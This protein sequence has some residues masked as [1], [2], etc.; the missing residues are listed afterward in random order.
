MKSQEIIRRY[1]SFFKA[2][3]HTVIPSAP[4]VPENDPT[5]LFTTAGMHP[6][7]PYFLGTEH[8]SG[9]KRLTSCQKCLRTV[10]IDEVGDNR[11]NTFFEMLGNWSLGDYFK[12]DSI[13]WSWQFLTDKDQGLGLDPSRLYITVF[14]GDS[15]AP[16]D[17]Q[18]VDLWR[19][20]FS[21]VGID[22][23]VDRPVE[24]GGRVFRLAKESN[25]WG[26]A[27]QTGP[28]G[29]DTEIYYDL[30]EGSGSLSLE[31]GMPDFDSG[32]LLEI[33]NNV[34]MQYAK[35]SDGTFGLL[36]QKNVDTGMGVERIA[37]ILQGTSTA[38]ETDL[39][40]PL[41]QH[42]PPLGV[43]AGRI[44]A[45]HL[46]AAC[47]LISDGVRPA[48]KDRG[49][50]LRRLIRRALLH[51]GQPD[52]HWLSS[53]M[54]AMQEIY[55]GRYPELVSDATEIEAVL[56]GE[57]A[58]FQ[59]TLEQ[60]KREIVK[61]Q[62]LT[63][64]DAFDL[65]QSYGF[66]LELTQEYAKEQGVAVNESEFAEEFKRHQDLSRTASA[67]QFRSGLADQ[68]E[69][70]TKYHTATHLLQASLRQVLGES[71]EQKG[72]NINA[73]RLR[74]DFSYPEKLTPEQLKDVEEMVNREITAGLTISSQSMSPEAARDQG[75]LGF[76][77]NKYG[78]IVSVFSIGGFSKE[79]CTG[80]HVVQ[81]NELGTFR[82]LKEEAVSAGVR[83]IKAILE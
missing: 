83:R 66:P 32:R 59:K 75:A 4:L 67:G 19:E 60:G 81:T 30:G 63:G 14:A 39:F 18:S 40:K 33:W 41:F 80:P 29:P 53:I 65:Y 73:E 17:L 44:V 37:T 61:R 8:P 25:W 82:I 48:N 58:K 3:D 6:L 42:L 68:S 35:N 64:K 38:Y 21:A 79:I 10:D 13:R 72:S 7:V 70:S 69:I 76:F 26:P 78:D 77:A 46:R 36:S 51:A 52:T 24:D 16:E 54:P 31:T 11:H 15:D 5:I 1:L 43:A 56:L 62:S 20:C 28:C 27:G 74:F 71:V 12:E 9:S 49:Y 57:A 50:V 22:A 2:R 34:F 45:D 23:V 55:A 47:L